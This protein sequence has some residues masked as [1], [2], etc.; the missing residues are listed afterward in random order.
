M[1][2]INKQALSKIAKRTLTSEAV[3]TFL[4]CRERNRGDTNLTRLKY[5]LIE[6]NFKIIPEDFMDTFKDLEAAGLGQIIQGKKPRFKWFVSL[7]EVGKTGL[8]TV[9]MKPVEPKVERV[10]EAEA[11]VPRKSMVICLNKNRDV[12]VE[13]PTNLTREEA[14]FIAS[15]LLTESR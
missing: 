4:G 11:V 3:F 6:E 7:K 13:L 14:Q 9:P 5:D 1:N 10:V 2:Q 15:K 8:S 12:T